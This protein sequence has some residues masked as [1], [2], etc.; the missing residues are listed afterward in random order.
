M[1]S[2][3]EVCQ[4]AP[5]S[6]GSATT[7]KPPRRLG[8]PCWSSSDKPDLG[9]ETGFAVAASEVRA[10]RTGCGRA[11]HRSGAKTQAEPCLI[12][13]QNLA[14]PGVETKANATGHDK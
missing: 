1:A 2:I 9:S 14:S 5:N 3:Y 11:V 13:R 6:A 12:S 4:S 10:C 8:Q 7:P